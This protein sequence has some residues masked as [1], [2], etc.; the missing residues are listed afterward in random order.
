MSVL[1]TPAAQAGREELDLL[2]R[3]LV[4]PPACCSNSRFGGHR[5]GAAADA[6]T[7]LIQKC[8]QS[9]SLTVSQRKDAEN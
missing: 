7:S 4:V 6:C 2:Q 5:A 3:V 1:D 9:R 8:M